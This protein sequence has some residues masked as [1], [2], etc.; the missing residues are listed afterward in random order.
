MEAERCLCLS[1]KTHPN[2]EEVLLSQHNAKIGLH[3]LV[4]ST[5][6]NARV[7]VTSSRDQA[8][9]EFSADPLGMEECRNTAGR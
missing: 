9:Y 6:L 7:H 4:F 5:D 2:K 3:F 8:A 1:E